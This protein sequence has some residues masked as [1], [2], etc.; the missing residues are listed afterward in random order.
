[1]RNFLDHE[2]LPPLN[3]S[4]VLVTGGTGSFGQKFT[5]I[6]LNRFKV[7]KLIIF[8][9]D[10]A[11]QFEMQNDPRF[12]AHRERMRFF[13][14]DIRDV[15]RLE[16]AFREVNYVVHAA[17]INGSMIIGTDDGTFDDFPREYTLCGAWLTNEWALVDG[18][19][20]NCHECA[21]ALAGKGLLKGGS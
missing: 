19:S 8:S 12:E 20:L 18:D 10:E 16:M 11:K 2:K 13:I 1:M 7:R 5:E 9:R 3:D 15:D 4:V 21:S 17:F 14:G 6:V